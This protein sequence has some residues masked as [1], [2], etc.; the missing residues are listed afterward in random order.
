[1]IVG[2][3]LCQGMTDA[4][5]LVLK[6]E[7]FEASNV[8]GEVVFFLGPGSR[9]MPPRGGPHRVYVGQPESLHSD[10]IYSLGSPGGQAMV[11]CLVFRAT[12]GS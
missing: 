2:G 8:E 10:M 5:D 9:F 7:P 3:Q 6:S 4:I 12:I 11:Y 1:M